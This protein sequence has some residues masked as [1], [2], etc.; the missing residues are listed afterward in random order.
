M[1]LRRA[2]S[3]FNERFPFLEWNGIDRQERIVSFQ[4]N[5][6]K[7]KAGIIFN[8][9]LIWLNWIIPMHPRNI[10][11][12]HGISWI[13]RRLNDYLIFKVGGQINWNFGE[14]RLAIN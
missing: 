3:L 2:S 13:D 6:K 11:I 9:R 8:R 5:K 4:R 10:T 12:N 1:I 7:E 14:T